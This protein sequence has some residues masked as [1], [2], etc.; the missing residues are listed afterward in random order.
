M[1]NISK[2]EKLIV[3]DLK[4]VCGRAIPGVQAIK[5]LFVLKL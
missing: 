5:I 1:I 2:R 4:L 3:K